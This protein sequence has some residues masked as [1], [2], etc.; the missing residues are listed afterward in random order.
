MRVRGG[1]LRKATQRSCA[2]VVRVVDGHM[3]R[4]PLRY[5]LVTLCEVADLLG[6]TSRT[7]WN[8]VAR[9]AL[10]PRWRG[11]RV[12]F[13]LSSVRARG[14]PNERRNHH[15]KSEQARG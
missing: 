13:L 7:V 14:R 6:V 12:L 5:G 8:L 3:Y 9:G 15:A 2:Q 4:R 1:D 11:S 10:R